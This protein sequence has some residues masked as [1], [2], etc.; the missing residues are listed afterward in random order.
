MAKG[1]GKKEGV[2][3]LDGNN[4]AQ[5]IFQGCVI[6]KSSLVPET[7]WL[8]FIPGNMDKYIDQTINEIIG[9]IFDLRKQKK[10]EDA[11]D[12]SDAFFQSFIPLMNILV[13]QKNF[14]SNQYVGVVNSKSEKH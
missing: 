5:D 3:Y 10:D 9:C 1:I 14:S 2:L 6:Q 13:E 8:T 4:F 7:S 11:I 12:F